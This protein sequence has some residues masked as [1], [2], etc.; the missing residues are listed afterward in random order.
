MCTHCKM[1]QNYKL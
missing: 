1:I